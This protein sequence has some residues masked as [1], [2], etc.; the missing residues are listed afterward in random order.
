MQTHAMA[1]A[2]R[3]YFHII[4]AVTDE[5][6]DIVYRIRYT[7]YC[8]E[9]GWEDK[10]AFPDGR[11]RDAYDA[12][13]LHCLL[14]HRPSDRFAGCVRLVLADPEDPYKPLPFEL[15]SGEV[16]DDDTLDLRTRKRD[17]FGEISRLAVLSAFRRRKGEEGQPEDMV[18]DGSEAK[19]ERR[20]FPHVALGLYLAAASAGLATGLNA[21]F[22]MME[23]RLAERIGR[24]GIRFQQVG[25]PVDYH[26]LRAP[27]YITRDALHAGLPA[28]G[29]AL[30]SLI[31]EELNRAPPQPAKA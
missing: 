22:A 13:S 31:Q 18:L 23:P 8:E 9:L 2:F 12:H 11:E 15:A 29:R 5:L 7:V 17:T 28:Q 25:R 1:Q 16:L 10:N 3:D 20:E 19:D 27:Y 26:G 14:R 21:V 24:Y 4:P 6:R 30:L